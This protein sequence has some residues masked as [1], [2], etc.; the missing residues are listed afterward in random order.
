MGR[1][2]QY[3]ARAASPEIGARYPDAVADFCVSLAISLQ[4]GVMRDD[5]RLGLRVTNYRKRTVI[6]FAV[7][8]DIRQVVIVGIRHGAE[9]Y[10]A[11][12]QEP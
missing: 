9:D 7:E 3:I 11:V 2:G 5:F 10:E 12:L 6:A 1:T 4:R 8:A